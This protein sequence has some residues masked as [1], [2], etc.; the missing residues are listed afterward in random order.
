MPAPV[1]PHFRVPLPSAGDEMVDAM[2]DAKAA[3][4]GD[5]IRGDSSDVEVPLSVRPKSR[6]GGGTG[7]GKRKM[8]VR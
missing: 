1:S 3:E 7:K 8:S 6:G 2:T 4:D 5:G